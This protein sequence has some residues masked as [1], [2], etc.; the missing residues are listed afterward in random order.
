[1]YTLKFLITTLVLAVTTSCRDGFLN[2]K[3]YLIPV[4]STLVKVQKERLETNQDK[5][6]LEKYNYI[7]KTKSQVND[8]EYM[9]AVFDLIT[10]TAKKHLDDEDF[11]KIVI[12]TAWKESTWEHYSYNHPK[13]DKVNVIVGDAG[14]AFGMFQINVRWH[15]KLTDLEE[16]IDYGTKM[17]K[18]LYALAK[19]ENCA[20]GTNKGTDIDGIARRVYAGYN[21]GSDDLCRN[22]DSRDEGFLNHFHKEPW[23]DYL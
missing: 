12:A 1:M 10:K 5:T 13:K 23:K 2:H 14:K 17:L 4:S 22:N 21:A 19:K 15:P 6:E 11:V 7:P 9:Q 8:Q 3:K 20:S 18:N 16:N